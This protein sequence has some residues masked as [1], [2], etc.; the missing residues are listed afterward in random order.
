MMIR[1]LNINDINSLAPSWKMM[2]GVIEEAVNILASKD[3]VQ[4]IKP[5][6]RFGDPKNR[7]I[8][9]PAYIG[10]HSNSVGIKWIASFPDNI[11]KNIPR[12]SALTIL[13]DF[14][15]GVPTAILSSNQLSGL[16]TAA[17]SGFVIN[18]TREFL[19]SRLKIGILG[20]GPIGQLHVKMVS[21]ILKDQ[22]E[23]IR[24]Y[25]IH[26]SA[27]PLDFPNVKFTSNW[28]ETYLNADI[29]IC[30]T[31]SPKRY[32]D[33]LPKPGSLHLNV[34]LRD[35]F[36]DIV[37]QSSVII[38]DNWEEVCRENTDIEQCAIQCGLNKKQTIALTELDRG[39]N[40]TLKNISNGY[41]SFHPMG[42]AVFDI[43]LSQFIY[44]LA[45][46]AQVGTRLEL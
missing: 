27:H 46:K 8:A 28:E 20:F 32:I 41:V 33:K 3:Y 35:Y 14:E 19:S 2:V 40:Q 25:D 31:T 6:L 22:I 13:N 1:Y 36:P 29:V 39:Y 16:R 43:I 34:S 42:M 44:E 4:P 5:Y 26:S 11:K 18:K 15:T 24:V 10:G 12:A 37:M 30:C 17:V 38:V 23:E 21:E 9:M 45:K 7:I